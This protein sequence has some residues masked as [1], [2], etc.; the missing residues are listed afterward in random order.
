MQIEGSSALVTGG[1]SGLGLATAR[2]LAGAGA[3][4]TVLDLPGTGDRIAGEEDLTFVAG[5]VRDEAAVARAVEL[6]TERG[7]LRVLVN[8]AGTGVAARTVGPDGPLPLAEFQR[9]V[10]I[11]LV[12]SFNVTRLAAAAMQHNEPVDGDRGVVI[13]TASVAAFEGQIGQAAYSASKGGIV[14]MTIPI[15]RDLAK[16]K[17]RV[18]TIAPGTFETPLLGSLNDEI[19]ASLA[20]AIPHPT[21]LGDPDEYALLAMHI[22]ENGMLNGETIRLDG[23]LRMAPR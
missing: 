15:A 22:V 7:D 12:G 3:H 4:V 13:N 5:D 8:C 21:R 9:I 1:T 10:D 18:V 6:S 20:A 16:L 2:R 19:R 17:I 11:N 23:A 14:G